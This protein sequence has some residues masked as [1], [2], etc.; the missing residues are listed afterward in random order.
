M[1]NG[2][3]EGRPFVPGLDNVE[4]IETDDCDNRHSE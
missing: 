2:R 1:A 3:N 4:E